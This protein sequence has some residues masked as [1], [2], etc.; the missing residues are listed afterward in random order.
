MN[1]WRAHADSSSFKNLLVKFLLYDHS[2]ISIL[3]E[4]Y[5]ANLLLFL[6]S[7]APETLYPMGRLGCK[8]NF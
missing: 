1:L 8:D 7:I 5:G 3:R 6:L 2:Y 4:F